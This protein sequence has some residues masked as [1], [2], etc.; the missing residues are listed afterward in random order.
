MINYNNLVSFLSSNNSKY[1]FSTL[2]KIA[3]LSNSKRTEE[4]A[5]YTNKELLN[6][7]YKELPYI[8]KK[9]IK[10]IEPSVGVGNFVPYVI[11]KYSYAEVLEIDV[12]DTNMESLNILKILLDIIDVP[13]NVKI[14]Y[15]ND[16]FL[17]HFFTCHYD[18]AV[19]NPPFMKIKSNNSKLH[20]YKKEC[21]NNESTNTS[22]YFLEKATKIADNVVM[23][24]PK[25]LLNTIE[26]K[27]TRD[28]LKQLN[29]RTIVDFGENGF[30]GVLI[31]T[32]CININT[33]AKPNETKIKSITLKES[34]TQKQKYIMDSKLPYWVIYR[35]KEFDKVYSEMIFDIFGVFRD[36]QITNSNSFKEMKATNDIWVIKSRNI[37]ED[38][39]KINHIREY[40]QY[41]N[42]EDIKKYGVYNYINDENIYITPNMTYKPRVCKK[43]K[44]TVVNGSVAILIP[45]N[46]IELSSKDMEYFSTEEYRNFYKIARNYQTRSLNIDKTSVFFFGK[47]KEV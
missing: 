21:I 3:E 37:S 46:N 16:D 17:L 45:K 42:E 47:R 26:Y 44:G 35:N 9:H 38:A 31:E 36:R 27:K 15:I 29:V 6:Y 10:I 8:N 28:Y 12:V 40:D 1:S 2:S 5:Y 20:L 32:I 22:T 43:P 24:M 30:E 23:I 7:I 11:S 13:Q 19:G 34:I 25:F 14:N 41:I 33:T 18:V 4:E 39:K